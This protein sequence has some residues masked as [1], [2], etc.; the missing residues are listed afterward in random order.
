MRAL[1]ESRRK[2]GGTLYQ[3]TF[4]FELCR[5]KNTKDYSISSG[6]RFAVN[7]SIV[8]FSV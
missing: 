3:V 8:C 2:S 1:D 4:R 5:V 7:S 6:K